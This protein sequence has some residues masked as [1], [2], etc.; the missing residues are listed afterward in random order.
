MKTMKLQMTSIVNKNNAE[1][2]VLDAFEIFGRTAESVVETL[3]VEE[4][5]GGGWVKFLEL[6]PAKSADK[7]DSAIVRLLPNVKR[8]TAGK[9]AGKLGKDIVSKISY[10]VKAGG[11]IFMFDSNKT[12]GRYEPC[13]VADGYWKVKDTKDETKMANFKKAFGYKKPEVALV[14]VLK[15]DAHPELVGSIM[16]LRIYEDVELLINK[17]LSPSAEDMDLN[18][19]KAVNVF[20]ILNSP[21]LMLKATMKAYGDG[22]VGRNFADSI[23]V[24]SAAYKHFLVPN[25]PAED[26]KP[27]ALPTF[28]KVQLTDEEI[29]LYA[30]KQYTPEILGKLKQVLGVLTAEGT[31]SQQDYA[32]AAPD[33]DA[34]AKVTVI[35]KS[36][37]DG[38]FVPDAPVEAPAASE[39]P[40]P[41]AE[42]AASAPVA[43]SAEQVN[44]A[45][46]ATSTDV[47]AILKAAEVAQ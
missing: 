11:K 21:A 10:K 20:D 13:P 2:V 46:P 30:S 29:P 47:D 32:Y 3:A 7:T 16:P 19:T 6:D 35:V 33:E 28:T 44:E 26:A 12:N 36:I 27:D 43:T 34:I 14:Q 45:E 31:V 15:Y 41:A 17:T 24:N 18:G 5:E 22:G 25:P 4:E 1:D 40:A 8:E 37:L 9:N 39:A 23:F 38:T 42:N